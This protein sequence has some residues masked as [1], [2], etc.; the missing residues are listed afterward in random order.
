MLKK[1]KFSAGCLLLFVF[2]VVFFI[3]CS[4]A[5]TSNSVSNANNA[6]A[7]KT[8]NPDC[9]KAITDLDEV[10]KK[11]NTNPDTSA[12]LKNKAYLADLD[13]RSLIKSLDD[14]N[15]KPE[16]KQQIVGR[17]RIIMEEKIKDLNSTK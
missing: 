11:I 5:N 1:L 8:G 13:K 6:A 3:G 17:C 12:E 14:P 7:Y 15:N 16:E 2:S 9:D 10:L 4:N